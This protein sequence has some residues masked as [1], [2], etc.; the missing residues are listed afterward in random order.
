M[1]KCKHVRDKYECFYLVLFLYSY[2]SLHF[3]PYTLALDGIFL[4]LART[5]YGE[6]RANTAYYNK[7]AGCKIKISGN[8]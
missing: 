3:S 6:K 8:E 7:Y 5:P 4:D 2:M 1:C